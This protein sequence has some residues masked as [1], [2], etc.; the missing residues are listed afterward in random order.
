MSAFQ[1]AVAALL[2]ANVV[3]GFAR[4]VRGPSAEDRLVAAQLLGTTAVAI[5]LLMAEALGAPLLRYVG[6]VF[7]S[8]AAVTVVAYVRLDVGGADS[9]VPEESGTPHARREARP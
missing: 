5:L 2:L 8:L 3:A 7:A 1:L 9:A 4:L 6:L